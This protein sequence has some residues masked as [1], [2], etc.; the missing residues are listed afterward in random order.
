[1]L[2]KTIK[3]AGFIIYRQ[4]KDGIIEFLGLEALDNMAARDGGK[5]DIPKGGFDEGEDPLDC[6]IRE[7]YEEACIYPK[8]IYAGP[9]MSGFLYVWI[10]N[11][12]GIPRVGINP[13]HHIKE[14]KSTCW[15]TPDELENNCFIYLKPFV[16][17]ARKELNV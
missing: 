16:K 15:V 12:R 3:G 9:M 4:N 13:K 1:M 10:A 14:H 11:T 8:T 2:D 17:W 7:C 5:W 6:A